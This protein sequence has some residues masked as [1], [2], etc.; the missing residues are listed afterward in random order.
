[1]RVQGGSE[2]ERDDDNFAVEQSDCRVP[3]MHADGAGERS[4]RSAG[5]KRS[6]GYRHYCPSATC[7]RAKPTQYC[8][9]RSRPA[10]CQ[11]AGGN[12]GCAIRRHFGRDRLAACRSGN[13]SG[14]AE[15]R[16]RL[17]NQDWRSGR[18]GRGSGNGCGAVAFQ[19][20]PAALELR[21]IAESI[22]RRA[23]IPE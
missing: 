16:S 11:Q 10:A 9:N 4:I 1:M 22:C 19:P 17:L 6:A 2:I 7:R 21:R 14:K 3:G 15:A 12:S 23:Y 20:Q 18:S 5:T 13:C 8:A